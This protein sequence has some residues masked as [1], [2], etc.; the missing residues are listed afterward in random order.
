[1]ID[2]FCTQ[3][4]YRTHIAPIWHALPPEERGTWWAAGSEADAGNP[5]GLPGWRR[6][7]PPGNRLT[8]VAGFLDYAWCPGPTVYLE[9][10][11]G[12]TYDGDPTDTT[13][14]GHEAYS[15]SRGHDR[16][17]LFLCPSETVAARWRERYETVPAVAVGCPK[18]DWWH[19]HPAA[20][21]GGS[22]PTVAITFHADNRLCPETTT[23]WRHYEAGLPAAVTDLRAAGWRVIGH[24]HPRLWKDLRWFWQ[25]IGVE[26]VED[27][28]LV[29]RD[30]DVLVVDNSSTGPEFASTGR[31]IV[32]MNAPWYRRHVDHG[33]RFWRWTDGVPTVDEPG[34]LAQVLTNAMYGPTDG[35]DRMVADVYV[36]ADGKAAA[37]AA[38]AILDIS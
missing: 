32:W 11:A 37:R 18:L 17:R 14:T 28:N 38:E 33:G 34:Q 24:G 12:Q 25:R 6:G 22:Q 4:H 8:V 35:R 13:A 23:A 15:G 26:P 27:F 10:G 21:G 5:E 20:G 29:L 3:S 2:V 19:T 1:M 16:A 30:A 36:A 9:H 31:P 7:Y